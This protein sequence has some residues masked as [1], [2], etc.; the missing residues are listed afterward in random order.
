MAAHYPLS[1]RLAAEALGTA[2]LLSAVVGSGIMAEQLSAGNVSLALLENSIATGAA[3][4]AMILA[5]GPIS[6]A[7]FNPAVTL[8]QATQK[9][10]SWQSVPGYIV[11]QCLGGIAGVYATHLMFGQH[12][13]QT[14]LHVRSGSSQLFSEFV[15]TFGLLVIIWGCSRVRMAAVPFAIG[16]YITSAYWFTASTSFAN[17]AV[18]LARCFTNTFAGIRATDGPAF[19]AMQLLGALAATVLFRWLGPALPATAEALLVR[20]PRADTPT[21]DAG[22]PSR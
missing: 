21:R 3:L 16:A 19:V 1:K 5:L 13:F 12:I 9:G 2:F 11:A 18:T 6:G 14:S 4:V 7:H 8:A 17:P 10:L 15:A 20:L 22:I